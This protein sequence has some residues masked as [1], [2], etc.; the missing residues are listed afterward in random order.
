MAINTSKVLV[1][2]I[3]G[4]VVANVI[5][6]VGNSF[7]LGGM[8][9]ADMA[10]LNPALAAPSNRRTDRRIRDLRHRL[11]H[12]DGLDL[13][14]HPSAIRPRTEDR[15]LRRRSRRGPSAP[16]WPDSSGLCTSS[17]RTCSSQRA[18]WNWSTRSYRRWSAPGSTQRSRRRRQRR[19]VAATIQTA[20][21][22]PIATL[23][24]AAVTRPMNAPHA[25]R[26]AAPWPLPALHSSDERANERADERTD[27]RADDRHRHAHERAD[28]S[29]DDRAPAGA[30]RSAVP[31]RESTGEHPLEPLGDHHQHADADHR[32]RARCRRP[33]RAGSSRA[34]PR[35]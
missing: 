5:D 16:Q 13:R 14:R 11:D 23:I 35:R 15:R 2:G 34:P 31:S 30:S 19:I 21:T 10:K 22:N 25:T 7:I 3:V 1:G 33:A 29:A 17:A 20:I 9:R 28:H 8:H 27:D 32:R 18:A 6:F 4:G 24:A 12:R 26:V